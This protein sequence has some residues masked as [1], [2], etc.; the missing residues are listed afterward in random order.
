[1]IEVHHDSGGEY[2]ASQTAGEQEKADSF[3]WYVLFITLKLNQIN[4]QIK[5][6]NRYST[7]FF[8]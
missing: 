5:A 6:S 4:P 2:G 7:F 8:E 1:M 3:R